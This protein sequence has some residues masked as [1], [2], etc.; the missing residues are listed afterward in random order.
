[1]FI[2]DPELSGSEM[3]FRIRIHNTAQLYASLGRHGP[4]GYQLGTEYIC[5]LVLH[6][7]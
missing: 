5:D 2:W 4:Y 7:A 3:I 6:A 1:M